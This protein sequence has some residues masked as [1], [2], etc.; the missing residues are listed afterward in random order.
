M[1]KE[2][3]GAGMQEEAGLWRALLGSF[4]A[5]SGEML[6]RVR[7]ENDSFTPKTKRF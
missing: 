5:G 1:C 2:V 6:K 3:G 4:S 7:E